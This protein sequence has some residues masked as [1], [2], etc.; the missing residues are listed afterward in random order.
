MIFLG[1]LWR[2]LNVTIVNITQEL[3]K[4]YLEYRDGHLWW[5]K[6]PKHASKIVKGSQS[7]S[8]NSIGY[9]T[10]T[11]RSKR[12]LEHRLIWL[13][14]CG[15]WPIGDIDHINGIRD[16]NRIEN[17]REVTRQQNLFNSTSKGGTSTYKGVS[18]D[19]SRNKWVAQ[20]MVNSK[21]FY[22]G[23]YD[24]EDLAKEAYIQTV[25]KVHKQHAEHK[26]FG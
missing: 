25:D 6:V 21:H 12:Y 1:Y 24:T 16:D 15:D 7:G 8:K 13:Y 2:L 20:Y 17:L 5:I 23:R 11:L 26:R 3:L 10:V 18:W 4:E 22:I 19:K 14:H 9:R